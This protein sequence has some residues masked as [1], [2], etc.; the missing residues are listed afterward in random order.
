MMIHPLGRSGCLAPWRASRWKL[1]NVQLIIVGGKNGRRL[2]RL[3]ICPLY[4][5]G[6]K[7]PQMVPSWIY[8]LVTPGFGG[9][10]SGPK[11]QPWLL[12]MKWEKRMF[13]GLGS[14]LELFVENCTVASFCW[15]KSLRGVDRVY[16]GDYC[17]LFCPYL[18]IVLFQRLSV[19]EN[20]A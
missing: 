19:K 14:G 5:F 17:R 8:I 11:L 2:P 20:K 9:F 3:Q 10:D 15:P 18:K 6:N 7:P 4:I 13:L 16:L 12:V 1:R